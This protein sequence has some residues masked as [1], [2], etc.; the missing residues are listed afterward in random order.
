[1]KKRSEEGAINVGSD[2]V[3]KSEIMKEYFQL[4]TT[5]D[6]VFEK[7]DAYRSALMRYRQASKNLKARGYIKEGSV[8]Y[9]RS[10]DC[11]FS[12]WEKAQW[13][14]LTPKGTAKA[15]ELCKG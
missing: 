6:Y 15:E 11:L 3:L 5:Y 8:F 9:E 7:T 4:E 13:I 2:M 1:M 14:E 10:F 12:H